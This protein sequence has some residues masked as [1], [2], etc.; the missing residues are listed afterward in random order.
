V[1]VVVVVVVV[2]KPAAYGNAAIGHKVVDW[3]LVPQN[4]DT[5]G[6]YERNSKSNK[7]QGFLRKLSDSACDIQ[8]S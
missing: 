6:F 4:R 7:G 3:I 2:V 1:V 5:R 8:D